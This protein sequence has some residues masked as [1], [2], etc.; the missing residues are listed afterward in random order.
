MNPHHRRISVANAVFA[1]ADSEVTIQLKQLEEAISGDYL[2]HSRGGGGF[3][4]ESLSLLQG[5]LSLSLSTHMQ[6]YASLAQSDA[7]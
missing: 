6:F 3:W 1:D 4:G 7:G 2:S 5:S